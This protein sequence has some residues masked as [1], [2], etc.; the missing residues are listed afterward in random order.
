MR[1]SQRSTSVNLDTTSALKRAARLLRLSGPTS[2]PPDIAES[3]DALVCPATGRRVVVRDGVIDLLGAGFEPNIGQRM[4]DTAPSAWFYDLVRPRLG[5]LLGM[6]TFD[7]EV[8][9]VVERLVLEP[10][11]TA[12]DIACGQG[13]FTLELARVVGPDGLV[14]G[15]D[16]AGAM[17][18]R[19]ARHLCESGMSNVVLLR[20]DALDLPFADACLASI[21][22]SGGLHQFP[23]VKRALAEMARTNR[24]GGRMAISGF[25]SPT[26]DANE[27]FRRWV[28]GGDM[29]FVP[30]D[31]LEADMQGA[32][33][34][35][36]GGEMGR[37]VGYRW[38]I[39]SRGRE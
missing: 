24:P 6:P 38:G 20:A 28:Q 14:I 9:N 5:P 3:G 18:K 11:S 4:L 31:E 27:G 34:E 35:Q 21:N 19:A 33:Y 30:M 23:D 7:S 26:R 36:V 37:W 25:A 2:P 1:P 15:L 29:N 13:N 12:L 10:G 22:C 8:K 17:L 16:I 39:R 32:G